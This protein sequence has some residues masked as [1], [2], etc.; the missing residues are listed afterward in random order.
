MKALLPVTIFAVLCAGTALAECPAP[1]STVNVPDGNTATMQEMLAAQSAVKTYDA[2]VKA[3]AAC[4]QTEQDAAVAKGGANMTESERTAINKRYT[5][6]Q[7]VE[8]D[9]LKKVADQFNAALKAYRAKNP[10]APK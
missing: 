2:D 8:V 3:F 5:E 6:M 4:L 7:N 1:A 9:K 10:P